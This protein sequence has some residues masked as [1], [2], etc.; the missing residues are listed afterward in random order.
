MAS[1]LTNNNSNI[2]SQYKKSEKDVI[3][4]LKKLEATVTILENETETVKNHPF[5]YNNKTHNL[6]DLIDINSDTI[7]LNDID[8]ILENLIT[9]FEIPI[10]L[11]MLFRIFSNKNAE[12]KIK[13]MTI[14][15]PYQI[16]KDKN[17]YKYILNIAIIYCGMG[18][19]SVLTMDKNTKKFFFRPDGGS[20]GYERED[21]YNKYYI[22]EPSKD[23]NFKNRLLS[24]NDILDQMLSV[25]DNFNL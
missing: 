18:H 13:N 23:E 6:N 3:N 8:P 9:E 11:A 16:I 21:Y 14:L 10:T 17:N 25:D 15:S 5:F 2:R 19:I 24:F 12:I 1:L 22:L 20:N 7:F 4:Y